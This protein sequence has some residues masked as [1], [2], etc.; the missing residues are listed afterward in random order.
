MELSLFTT[1]VYPS[2][3]SHEQ[4]DPCASMSQPRRFSARMWHSQFVL[5][6]FAAVAAVVLSNELTPRRDHFNY[7]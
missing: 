4:S 3:S 7:V 6:A 1:P 5:I 2:A